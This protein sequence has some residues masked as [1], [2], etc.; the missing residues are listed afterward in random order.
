[1]DQEEGLPAAVQKSPYHPAVIPGTSLNQEDTHLGDELVRVVGVIGKPK[2]LEHTIAHVRKAVPNRE[3]HE[4]DLRTHAKSKPPIPPAIRRGTATAWAV[5]L[6]MV[7]IISAPIIF[8]SFTHAPETSQSNH[9]DAIPA[10][11]NRAQ[12]QAQSDEIPAATNRAQQQAQ[13]DE[14]PAATNRAQQQA[15]SDEIPAATNRAQQAQSSLP[16]S[17]SGPFDGRWSATVGP[18]GGCNFTSTLILD[19]VGS[20]IVGNATNPF[21]VF[22]LTGT[23]DPSGRGLF[24][25]GRFTGTIRFSGTKFE[26][27]YANDCGGRFAIGSKRTAENLN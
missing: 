26:A 17:R 2:D 3:H 15:Q 4:Q 25:I 16:Q 23:V 10:A 14:I 21:G 19:V 9:S 11:T 5:S 1:M 22:P 12:Q 8:L 20:S 27:N 6:V 24:K 7:L 18:Q 13:S